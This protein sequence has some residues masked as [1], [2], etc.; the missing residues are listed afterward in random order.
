MLSINPTL[1]PPDTRPSTRCT[2]PLEIPPPQKLRSNTLTQSQRLHHIPNKPV[3]DENR[4]ERSF[5]TSFCNVNND[6][7]DPLATP[8]Q[9]RSNREHTR[10]SY[11][12]WTREQGL[13]ALLLKRFDFCLPFRINR[14]FV[15]I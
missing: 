4:H 3:V 7:S 6:T 15:L 13:L 10:L 1:S 9:S 11:K 8:I 14:F 12:A 2:T 5:V